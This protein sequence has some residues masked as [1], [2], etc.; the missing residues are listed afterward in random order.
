MGTARR[1][2]NKEL[3]KV[4]KELCQEL[5]FPE[6]DPYFEYC[7]LFPSHLKDQDRKCRDGLLSENT[8]LHTLNAELQ[9][10]IE[11]QKFS[12]EEELKL[13]H[14]RHQKQIS[15][16]KKQ[17]YRIEENCVFEIQKMR[18]ELETERERFAVGLKEARNAVGLVYTSNRNHA[19]AFFGLKE[20]FLETFKKLQHRVKELDLKAKS[21]K[22]E[23]KDLEEV[24]FELLSEKELQ[25]LANLQMRKEFERIYSECRYF[26]TKRK[27]LVFD[28]Y[29]SF[30]FCYFMFL[31]LDFSTYLTFVPGMHSVNTTRQDPANSR[32]PRKRIKFKTTRRE[33][34]KLEFC[35]I[36]RLVLDFTTLSYF[37]WRAQQRRRIFLKNACMA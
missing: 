8:R 20:S 25:E 30:K 2:A 3:N 22:R 36:F 7:E 9:D 34:C 15:D 31:I 17:T 27:P 29:K 24:A 5:P 35:F 23:N 16:L 1:N 32:N 26:Q 28:P 18:S 33:P 37:H 13:R 12:Y 10:L 4:I 11:S 6:T 19:D 21:L 14:E